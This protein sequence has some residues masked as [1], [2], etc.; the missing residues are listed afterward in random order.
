MKKTK[1]YCPSCL[2]ELYVTHRDRVQDLSEH[3]SDPN[4]K[5][6]MK[7][8]YECTN[9]ER[10]LESIYGSFWIEDGDYFV[11]RPS[12]RTQ[13]YSELE[14]KVRLNRKMGTA[15]AIN[16]WNY[17]YD[18]GKKKTKEMTKNIFLGKYRFEIKPKEYGYKYPE[19]LWHMPNKWRWEVSI[20][21][22]SEITEWGRSESIFLTWPRQ[23]KFQLNRFNEYY[24]GAINGYRYS[25]NE[26]LTIIKRKQYRRDVVADFVTYLIISVFHYKK[27]RKILEISK[28]EKL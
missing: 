4:G 12:Y 19:H 26:C 8:I 1:I 27:K 22:A 2:S 25:L 28:N 24:N 20:Y 17:Y 10:C 13:E 7:D 14:Q 23:I 5:P 6:S 15:H 16:S 21:I 18:L 3:V 11:S 9:F